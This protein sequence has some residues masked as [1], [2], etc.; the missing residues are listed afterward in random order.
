MWTCVS[1]VN[2]YADMCQRNQRLYWHTVNYFTLVNDTGV[3]IDYADTVLAHDN[4]NADTFG[5]NF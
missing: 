4:D 5:K 3:V 2:D 1:L